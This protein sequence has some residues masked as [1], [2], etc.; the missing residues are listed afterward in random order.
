MS[1]ALLSTKYVYAK[2]GPMS[3]DLFRSL[4]AELLQPLAEYDGANPYH[5]HRA[6]IT[7][8]GIALAKP[9][10][11]ELTDQE[12]AD[13]FAQGCRDGAINSGQPAFLRG[14]RAAIAADRARWGTPAD[15]TGTH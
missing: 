11:A 3:A 7:R 13:A 6:L 8:A 5:E 1:P 14:A 10:P 15:N 2:G 12:V 4:C 9:E